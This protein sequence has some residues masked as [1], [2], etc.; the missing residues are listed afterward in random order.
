[1]MIEKVTWGAMELYRCICEGAKSPVTRML[2]P[3][4]GI[5]RKGMEADVCNTDDFRD[6]QVRALAST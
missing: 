6:A 4:S 1:M 5:L 3:R 2:S